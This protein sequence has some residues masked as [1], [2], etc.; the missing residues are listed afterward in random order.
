MQPAGR[1]Q[2]RDFLRCA[3]V[4]TVREVLDRPKQIDGQRKTVDC[5]F[6]EKLMITAAAA[7]IYA[8]DTRSRHGI[9]A[10]TCGSESDP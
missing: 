10:D 1:H 2:R 4:Y 3:T 6:E 7:R 8:R 9:S 5:R